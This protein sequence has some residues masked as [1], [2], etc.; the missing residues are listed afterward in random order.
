MLFVL[1]LFVEV[2]IIGGLL[3]IQP[4]VVRR[5]LLFGV[6]VGEERWDGDEA[7]AITRRWING[8]LAGMAGGLGLGLLLIVM[9]VGEP[10]VGLLVSTLVLVLTSYGVY[11]RAYFRAKALAAPGAPA[12]AAALVANPPHSLLL[13]LLSLTIAVSAGAVAVGYAWGHYANLPAMVPTHFGPSGRP[14]AWSP[15]SLWSVMLLP[16]GA[17]VVPSAL[18]VVACLIA[19]A[20][21]AIRRADRGV[22]L[23]AQMRF[24]NASA[25]FLSG[26]VILVSVMMSGMALAGVRTAL[27]LADGISH[28][29]MAWTIVTVVY[30]AGGSLYIA[31]RYGQGGARLERQAAGAPLTNGVAD[32][33][34]WY[35]GGFYVNRDDPSILVEKRFGVGYTINL[36]NPKAVAL[37]LLFLAIVATI[38]VTGLM[39]PQ[40]H[41]PPSR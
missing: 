5:G 4:Y 24:R 9:R 35:L 37:L 17:L 40:T 11:L 33:S 19:R 23:A 20:K 25:T 16:L 27:G 7:R 39:T 18:G 29:L 41:T 8:M 32:N 14:D 31:I 3:L 15:R 36:G 21:R 13:P 6:Y 12:A 10:A 30:A 28:W 34:R 2:I 22:S 1:L 26:T 38:V